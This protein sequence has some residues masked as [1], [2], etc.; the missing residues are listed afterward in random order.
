MASDGEHSW[1]GETRWMRDAE[2]EMS[3]EIRPDAGCRRG[4]R[5]LGWRGEWR[6]SEE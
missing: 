4:M 5:V 1:H 2:E 6:D 3:K